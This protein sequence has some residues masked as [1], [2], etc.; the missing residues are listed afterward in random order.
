MTELRAVVADDDVLLREGL[1]S[2]LQRSGVQVLGQCG[3]ATELLKLVGTSEP[4]LVVVDVRMP[5]GQAVA[6]LE[7]ARV[8]R[9]EH[10]DIAILV[11]RVR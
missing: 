3:D 7:A 4:D 2:L 6:G 8:I 5:P 1:S 10:P 9:Q 11:L